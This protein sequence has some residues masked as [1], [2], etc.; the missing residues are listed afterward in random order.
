[1]K[2]ILIANKIY[3][4][5]FG[6][7]SLMLL[8]DSLYYDR[9]DLKTIF[10]LSIINEVDSKD[11]SDILYNMYAATHNEAEIR[12]MLLD[13]LKESTG[14]YSLEEFEYDNR[15]EVK[16][17]Y[18]I[19]VGQMQVSPQIFYTLTTH[20]IELM[21]KGFLQE[22]ENEANYL[23]LAL[24]SPDAIRFPIHDAKEETHDIAELRHK[25]FN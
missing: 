8:A 13:V 21:Y 10:F 9:Q 23:K 19:V 3:C 6:Q 2:Y 20:E 16:D 17:L 5:K 25:F 15:K 14:D 4:L 18:Q 11:E 22:K 12:T 1:M 24:T 7:K